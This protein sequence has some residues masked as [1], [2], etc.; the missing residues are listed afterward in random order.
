MNSQSFEI[1]MVEEQLLIPET[2]QGTNIC[3]LP[4]YSLQNTFNKQ[5]VIGSSIL[6]EYYTVF[7]LSETNSTFSIALKNGSF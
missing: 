2:Y 7:N 4:F 1:N 3:R 5:W 6:Q